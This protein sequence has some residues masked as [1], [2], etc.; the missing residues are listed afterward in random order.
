MGDK[1]AVTAISTHTF[2]GLKRPK[3]KYH[4]FCIVRKTATTLVVRN[5]KRQCTTDDRVRMKDGSFIGND[6]LRYQHAIACT[7]EMLNEY[8]ETKLLVTRFNK[9]HIDLSNLL[10]KPVHKLDLSL[11]QM[12]HLAK[13][14]DE[15]QKMTNQGA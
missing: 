8:E 2:I 12:E 7:Q 10:D 6:A 14:W 15:A 13:A 4:I 3:Q 11:A 5:I 9:A 1:V